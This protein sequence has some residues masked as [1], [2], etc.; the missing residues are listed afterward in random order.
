MKNCVAVVNA[1]PVSYVSDDIEDFIPITPLNFLVSLP[2]SDTPDL[3]NIQ[4]VSLKRRYRYMQKIREVLRQRFKNE[5]LANVIQNGSRKHENLNIGDVLIGYDNVKSK[6]FVA[7]GK[8][9]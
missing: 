6:S 9:Y 8:N 3:D 1:R 5:Y 2:H 7:Y 4:K